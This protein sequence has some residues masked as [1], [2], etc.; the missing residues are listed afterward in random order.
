MPVK[1]R[2]A[3]KQSSCTNGPY[4]RACWYNGYS[5]TTDFD[6][7]RPT[8]GNIVNQYLEITDATCN[9]DGGEER[10]CLL[11]NGLYPGPVACAS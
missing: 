1:V 5:I 9:P 6:L 11:V 8:T 7:R 4:T 10:I 3:R 2:E